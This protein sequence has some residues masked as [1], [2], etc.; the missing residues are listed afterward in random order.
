MMTPA[1]FA[2]RKTA[3]LSERLHLRGGADVR[4]VQ[5]LFGHRCLSTTALYTRVAIEDLRQL[6]ARAHPRR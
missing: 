4:H 6:I 3:L 2:S 1:P 5:E